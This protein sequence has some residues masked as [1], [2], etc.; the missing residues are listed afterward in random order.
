MPVS[1]LQYMQLRWLANVEAQNNDADISCHGCNGS[2]GGGCVALPHS[3]CEKLVNM[4]DQGIPAKRCYDIG[5]DSFDWM[6]VSRL[7]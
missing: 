7:Q 2:H 4:L 6:P 5:E 1:R 3:M